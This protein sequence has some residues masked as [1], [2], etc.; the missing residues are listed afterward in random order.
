[1]KSIR[2]LLLCVC[3]PSLPALCQSG[4][5]YG[6]VVSGGAPVEFANIVLKGTTRGAVSDAD[7]HFTIGQVPY[8]TYTVVLSSIGYVTLQKSIKVDRPSLH[9]KFVMTEDVN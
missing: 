1:M 9:E 5:L 8:G 4:E 7:G 3:I 2:I 6:T